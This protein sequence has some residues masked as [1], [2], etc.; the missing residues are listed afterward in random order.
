MLTLQKAS[1][2]L[3]DAA[4][5]KARNQQVPQA[6]LLGCIPLKGQV[7]VA[8]GQREV[9]IPTINVLTVTNNQQLSRALGL[10]QGRSQPCLKTAPVTK[11][12]SQKHPWTNA[13]GLLHTDE[14]GLSKPSTGGRKASPKKAAYKEKSCKTRNSFLQN[15]GIKS[16]S[17][18]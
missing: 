9:C 5:K 12:P 8:D 11:C 18:L 16:T 1:L 17:F 3:T 2:L 10:T 7:P 14:Y 13:L 6:G 4:R 15:L